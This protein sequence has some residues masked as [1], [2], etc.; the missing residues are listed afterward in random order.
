MNLSLKNSL[1]KFEEE[2]E[3]YSVR[4]LKQTNNQLVLTKECSSHES[5]RIKNIQ[6]IKT[7][8]LKKIKEK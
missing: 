1:E 2:L 8:T 3:L 7:Q 5:Y 6:K 4:K